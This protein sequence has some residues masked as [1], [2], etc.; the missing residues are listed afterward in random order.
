MMKDTKENQRKREKKGISV[1]NIHDASSWFEV[2]QTN[3]RSQT[4]V[5]TLR[6]GASTGDHPEAHEDSQQVLF[7]IEGELLAELNGERQD[8]KTGDIIVI[9]PKVRHRFTNTGKKPA[10]TFNVYCPPEYS[11]DERS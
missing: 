5:M 8:L 10:M 1:R 11:P 7:L 6:S 2:L 4:A 9:P 3:D